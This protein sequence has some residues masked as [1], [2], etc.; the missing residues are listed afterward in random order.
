MRFALIATAAAAVVAVPFAA[1]MAGPQMT[2]QEFLAAVRCTAYQNVS[3]AQ[4]VGAKYE[5]NGEGQRQT[6]E[7]VA[8]AEAEVSAITRQAVNS[9]SARDRA[10]LRAQRAAA[11]STS[12]AE[13]SN[14][15]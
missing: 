15:V 8:V 9:Q 3:G 7:T 4:V 6:A 1:A 5:L 13:R 11:C 14:A 10:M 2:S 12:V